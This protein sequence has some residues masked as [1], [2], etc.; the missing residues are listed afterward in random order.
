MRNRLKI[1]VLLLL[2]CIF[3]FS[4]GKDAVNQLSTENKQQNQVQTPPAENA[5]M[6]DTLDDLAEA[7]E[8]FSEKCVRCHKEDGTGGRTNID[9]VEIRVP[10][11]RSERMKKEPDEDFIKAIR[12]GIPDE[13]MPSFKD[14]LND[15]QIKKLVEFIRKEFQGK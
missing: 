11:F 6:P 7:R 9:G 10:N 13:G 2:L 8:L 12:N 14:E 4:C 5:K 15:A 3:A 1:S